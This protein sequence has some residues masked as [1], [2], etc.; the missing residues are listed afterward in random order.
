S[1]GRGIE[2]LV[3]SSRNQQVTRCAL[4]VYIA[5]RQKFSFW[6]QVTMAAGPYRSGVSD[7]LL[8]RA[9][10]VLMMMILNNLIRKLPANVLPKAA[11]ETLA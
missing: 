6:Q 4:S 10:R 2:R 9:R 3:P 7:A 8:R 11:W 5:S 1:P